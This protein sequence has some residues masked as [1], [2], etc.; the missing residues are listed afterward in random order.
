MH[1]ATRRCPDGRG[2]PRRQCR[3]VRA[4]PSRG[5]VPR[6]VARRPRAA[7]G[8]LG[9]RAVGDGGGDRVPAS[10]AGRSPCRASSAR[11]R[12]CRCSRRGCRCRSRC[13]R[14]RPPGGGLPVAVLRRAAAARHRDRR[15]AARAPTARR[16]RV[17]LA[18]FLRA[19]HEPSLVAALGSGLARDPIG[20]AD[21][22]P[23]RAPDAGAVRDA[24]VARAVDRAAGRRRRCSMRRDPAAARDEALVHGDLHV[25]HVL[26]GDDGGPRRSST[27][28]TSPSRTPRSTCRSTGASSMRRRGRRSAR[29]TAPS[30][31]RRRGCSGPGCS[32]CSST[33]RSPRT[34]TTP[35]TRRCCARRSR[36]SSARCAD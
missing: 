14:G 2:R 27:G 18:G 26:V 22:T 16:S 17:A 9:Q 11:S 4:R 36:G 13:R 23:P 12:S 33:R 5:A 10:R 25:R 28:A 24:G 1:E 3:S 30:G 29:R 19:L 15:R 20:R 31:S 32:R 6:R 8:G 35:A 7:R 21:M 34:R